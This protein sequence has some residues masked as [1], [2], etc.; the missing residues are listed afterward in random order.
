MDFIFQTSH[1]YDRVRKGWGIGEER[2]GEGWDRFYNLL[3]IP[4]ERL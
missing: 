2:E 4:P 1:H 3:I